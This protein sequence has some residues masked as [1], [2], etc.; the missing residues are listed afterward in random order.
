MST[1]LLSSQLQIECAASP[2]DIASNTNRVSSHPV[3]T[4]SLQLKLLPEDMGQ[5]WVCNQIG[6]PL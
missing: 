2:H 1:Y 6:Q 4:V 3:S 5:Q